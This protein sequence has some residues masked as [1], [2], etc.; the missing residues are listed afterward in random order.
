MDSS[1][2]GSS[3]MITG[4]SYTIT[5]LSSGTSYDITVSIFHPAENTSINFTRS[6]TGIIICMHNVAWFYG[7]ANNYYYYN[8]LESDVFQVDNTDISFGAIS[9]ETAAGLV[10]ALAFII[11]ITLTVIVI[12]VVLLRNR[13]R[14]STAPKSR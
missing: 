8:C 14:N 1:E 6:T 11:S 7:R 13:S 5:D 12:A 2:G 10:V 4:N 3:G 9:F